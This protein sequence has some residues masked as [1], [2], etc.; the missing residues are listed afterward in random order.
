MTEY[1]T[2]NLQTNCLKCIAFNYDKFHIVFNSA[3]FDYFRTTIKAIQKLYSHR[4]L[5]MLA[6]QN[7]LKDEHLKFLINKYT[8][9]LN[10]QYLASCEFSTIDERL[11]EIGSVVTAFSLSAIPKFYF[12]DCFLKHLTRI[13]V[14][15]LPNTNTTDKSLEIISENCGE[16]KSLDVFGCEKVSDKGLKFLCQKKPPL[17]S[18][19]VEHTSVSYKGVAMIL[20][21]IST[22]S[23]L[24]FD[25]MPRAI[26]EAKG[27]NDI[28]GI[29]NGLIFKL[30]NL[31][32]LNNPMRPENHLTSILEV[33]VESCPDIKDLVVSEII[34]PEQTQ[35]ISQ[36]ENLETAY[37]QCS[38]IVSP[39]LGI[40]GFLGICGGKLRVLSL[41]S[42]SLSVE[43]LASCCPNLECITIQ[44]PSFHEVNNPE[45]S[46][47]CLKML[48]LQNVSL[49]SSEN[50][51]SATSIISSSPNLQELHIVHC[52]FSEVMRE[53]ILNC[54]KKLLILN[55]SN[56]PVA[57]EFLE[58]ILHI[59]TDLVKLVLNNSGITSD[60]YDDLMDMVDDMESK[61]YISWA[62]YSEAIRELFYHDDSIMNSRRKRYI[63]KL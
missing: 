16:L 5:R 15:E 35:L 25:N 3:T 29:D 33:C 39:K 19:N 22:I 37:L 17:E 46:F 45:L 41:T 7:K 53:V 26:F 1:Q 27:L 48:N 8:K 6:E 47:P 30:N 51:I 20:Q 50:Q 21:R 43:V 63:L 32:V 57:T 10:L 18:L 38:T 55:F 14:L 24:Q 56:T 40:N 12:S 59:H 28:M 2:E 23:K 11:Q 36:F 52:Q 62:D 9:Q 44:Y 60:D 31:T 34:T 49:D 4:I 61:V 58:E 42:F 54:P 13:Q